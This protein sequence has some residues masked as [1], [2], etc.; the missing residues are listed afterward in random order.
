MVLAIVVSGK[1]PPAEVV[2]RA[3]RKNCPSIAHTYVEPVIFYEYMLETGRL[4]R[5]AGLLNT[6]H[7]NGYIN[8]EPLAQLA[9]VPKD[10]VYRL[11][12]GM[13]RHV[14]LEALA[15]LCAALGCRD[16]RTAIA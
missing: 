9:E 13:A 6:I 15:R 4:A 7:S 12:A 3:R 14:D 16:D 2:A 1:R 11:D 5:P 10:M 8:P